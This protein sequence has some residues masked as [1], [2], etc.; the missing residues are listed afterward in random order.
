MRKSKQNLS[1]S[2][3]ESIVEETNLNQKRIRDITS[4]GPGSSEIK[5]ART[6]L[7]EQNKVRQSNHILNF[8]QF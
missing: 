7:N 6:E 8:R 3:G 2:I 1:A 4:E 5:K